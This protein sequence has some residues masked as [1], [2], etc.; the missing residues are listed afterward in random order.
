MGKFEVF[1]GRN[2]QLYFH[3]KAPN[4]EIIG[5]SEGYSQKQSAIKGI[6]SVR[7]NSQKEERFTIFL[8]N[9]NRYYFRL[10][11]ANN[12][13]ILHSQGY[14]DR[15]GAVV[16]KNAVKQYAPTAQAYDIT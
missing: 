4:N 11:A 8:G 15:N 1:T 13:I 14:K 7:L 2:Q 12:E 16:G 5:T 3:L 6:E 9:D 10:Q